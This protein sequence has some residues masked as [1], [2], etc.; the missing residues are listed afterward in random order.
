VPAKHQVVKA[1]AKDQMTGFQQVKT[2]SKQRSYALLASHIIIRKGV[3]NGHSEGALTGRLSQQYQR[4]HRMPP[5]S[6]R[7]N[8]WV[9][10]VPIVYKMTMAQDLPFC[11][12]IYV[13]TARL[14]GTVTN[15]GFPSEH[16]FTVICSHMIMITI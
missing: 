11:T 5:Q 12:G 9:S 10:W 6:A 15:K 14:A 8:F 3:H 4:T 13:K 2:R 1:T 7:H 16:A